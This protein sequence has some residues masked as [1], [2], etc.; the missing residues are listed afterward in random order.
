M[1]EQYDTIQNLIP[2]CYS[3]FR[4]ICYG[5]NKV[6]AEGLERNKDLAIFANAE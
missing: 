1:L 3:E 2:H 4:H 5:I 6:R